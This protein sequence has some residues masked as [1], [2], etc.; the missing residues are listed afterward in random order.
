MTKPV[1]QLVLHLKSMNIVKV[2]YL[3]LLIVTFEANLC[4]SEC[5]NYAFASSRLLYIL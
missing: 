1:D 3:E 5:S 2:F 4:S